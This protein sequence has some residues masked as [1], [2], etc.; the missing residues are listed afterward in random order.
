MTTEQAASEPILFNPFDPSFRA[1]PYPVY[2]RLRDESPVH[3]SP[4]GFF[5]LTRYEDCANLLRDPRVSNDFANSTAA[6]EEAAKQGIDLD[7]LLS[8]T[9]GR[10][11]SWIRRITRGCAAL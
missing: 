11:C 1:D 5:V 4:L 7:Q 8:R 9:R 6:I 2:R 10:S 3:Q